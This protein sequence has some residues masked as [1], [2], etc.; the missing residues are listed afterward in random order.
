[1]SVS[2]TRVVEAAKILGNFYRA[3]SIALVNELKVTFDRMGIDIDN[4]NAFAQRGLV[5]PTVGKA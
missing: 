2:G 4:R 3:V 1:M 5:G